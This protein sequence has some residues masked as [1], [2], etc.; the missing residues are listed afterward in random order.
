MS[1]PKLARVVE[2][3]ATDAAFNST[4]QLWTPAV[5]MLCFYGMCRINEALQMKVG[6]FQLNLKRASRDSD[7][8][9]IHYGCFTI[10]DRKNDHDPHS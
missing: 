9:T 4:M 7:G 5:C 10:R 6:D 3:L 2:Y 1:L 8:V